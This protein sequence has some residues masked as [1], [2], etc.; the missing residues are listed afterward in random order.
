MS[1][2]KAFLPDNEGIDNYMPSFE[3]YY[4]LPQFP[5]VGHIASVMEGDK[6]V[7]YE[8]NEEGLWVSI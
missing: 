5:E 4:D 7:K 1:Y 6:I 3:E 8:F 2:I